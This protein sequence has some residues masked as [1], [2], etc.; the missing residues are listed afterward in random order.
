[1]YHIDRFDLVKSAKFGQS[2]LAVGTGERHGGLEPWNLQNAD[3]WLLWRRLLVGPR[4]DGDIVASLSEMPCQ[5]VNHRAYTA[6]TRRIFARDHGDVH[7]KNDSEPAFEC[8]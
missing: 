8:H 5:M 7:A 4:D 1:M 3:T 6:P 2:V